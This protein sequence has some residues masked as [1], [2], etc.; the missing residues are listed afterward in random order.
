MVLV[1]WMAQWCVTMD[2]IAVASALADAGGVA[3]CH[4][5]GHDRLHRSF[6]DADSYGDVAAANIRLLGETHQHVGMV[7]KERPPGFSVFIDLYT[8]AHFYSSVKID[9]F[10]IV[11]FPP[12]NAGCSKD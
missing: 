1:K 6:G 8:T 10:K 11:C 4:K 3:L 2:R 12:R 5:I 7:G 9:E